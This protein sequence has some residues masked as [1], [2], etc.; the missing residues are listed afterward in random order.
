MLFMNMLCP[1][2]A[3]AA[4]CPRPL[5]EQSNHHSQDART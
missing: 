5:T 4:Q 1:H 2:C 3:A